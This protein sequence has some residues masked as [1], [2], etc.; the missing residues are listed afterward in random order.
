MSKLW[1]LGVGLL[2]VF[3]VLV[4]IVVFPWFAKRI[5]EQS[6]EYRTKVEA[7]KRES[8]ETELYQPAPA[9]Q[10]FTVRP[11]AMHEVPNAAQRA[12]EDQAGQMATY[13]AERLAWRQAAKAQAAI[14]GAAATGAGAE[15]PS[16]LVTVPPGYPARGPESTNAEV[17][18]QVNYKPVEDIY[19]TTYDAQF[20]GTYVFRNPD[21]RWPS[22]IVLT[23]PFPPKAN[24]LSDLKLLVDGKEATNTRVS[25]DGVT[26]AGWFKPSERKTVKVT[27]TAQGID[28]Y[29]YA[30]DQR[31]MNPEFR[32]I[33]TIKGADGDIEVPKESLRLVDSPVDEDGGRKLTWYYK[34]LVTT[35]NILIDIPDREPPLTFAARL[36]SYA[37]RFA[38]LSQ[39][40][41]IFAALFI[42]S[43]GLSGR[44]GGRTLDAETYVLL[45]LGFLFFYPLLIFI[46]N[47][48]SVS[49]SFWIAVLV[50]AG[51]SAAF[52]WR[53][54]GRALLWRTLLLLAVFLGLFSYAVLNPRLTGLL[55]TGGGIVILGFF[56]LSYA[57]WPPPKPVL[58]QQPEEPPPPAPPAVPEP[59]PVA[60]P[61]HEDRPV[62]C[63]C[64]HCGM[65]MQPEFRF[66]PN[67]AKPVH[68]VVLCGACGAEVCAA[69]GAGFKHCPRCGGVLVA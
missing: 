32:F 44:V 4:L 25:M 16:G 61:G 23:F 26:W 56:M 52:A 12:F 41:P 69:C 63:F 46:A 59:A 14:P 24:T 21:D 30:L 40:A 51:L 10:S 57:V 5:P 2:L 33:A 37:E 19:L 50:M 60:N 53:V 9:Y 58:P 39:V 42:G 1:R 6:A 54:G 27:Y 48:L 29:G 36:K 49:A 35:R 45:A 47:F 7:A 34:G 65:A 64:P 31:T 67:C 8:A 3:V 18:V 11:D 17:T 13:N 22:R 55:L 28:D 38:R 66:C 43:L 20:Q 68:Q 62:G 15:P